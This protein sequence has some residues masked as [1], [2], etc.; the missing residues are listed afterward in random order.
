MTNHSVSML[1]RNVL[2]NLTCIHLTLAAIGFP[3]CCSP[4]LLSAICY[5][6]QHLFLKQLFSAPM[7]VS[8]AVE[9]MCLIS[10]L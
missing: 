1:D 4:P 6:Q 9:L 3:L 10:P 5:M 8:I 7:L 2:I